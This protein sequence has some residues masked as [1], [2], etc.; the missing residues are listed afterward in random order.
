MTL[1]GELLKAIYDTLLDARLPTVEFPS[2]VIEVK[3]NEISAMEL[4]KEIMA[5]IK[6]F[7]E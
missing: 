5:R 6:P 1:N 7:L 2:C 3:L 4:A